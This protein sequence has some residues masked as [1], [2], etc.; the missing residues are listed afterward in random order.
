MCLMN[1]WS[2][3]NA[4]GV[5]KPNTGCTECLNNKLAKHC[6]AVGTQI[7]IINEIHMH[8]AYVLT[9]FI[10]AVYR[11]ESLDKQSC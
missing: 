2:Q 10:A 11:N 5:S 6:S 9:Y 3:H 7:K 1:I 4:V 8:Q